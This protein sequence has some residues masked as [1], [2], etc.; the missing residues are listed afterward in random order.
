MKS[1]RLVM[2]VVFASFVLLASAV[3]QTGTIRVHVP[4]DFIAG[5]QTLAAGDYKVSINGSLLQMARIDGSGVAMVST[6]LTGGGPNQDMT[7]R[8]VFHCY[9]NHCFLSV[10]WIG[11]INQGHELYVSSAELEYARTIKQDQ[12]IVAAAR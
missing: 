8:L 10:A 4:F 9:A 11:E 1:S 7:P 3:A 6:N 2:L 12:K 5:T